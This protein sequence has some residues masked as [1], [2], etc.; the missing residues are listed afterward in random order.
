MQVLNVQQIAY[1]LPTSPSKKERKMKKRKSNKLK[2]KLLHEDECFR[3]GDGGDLVLC[4]RRNCPKCY[5]LKCLH[6]E[7]EP[8]GKWD[9]P[10]H[11]CDDCGKPSVKLCSECPNSFCQKHSTPDNIQPMIEDNS[12]SICNDH[13]EFIPILKSKNK[14]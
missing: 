14:S 6:L 5:H 7:Q 2:K 3:C 10:W 11:H 4:D 13:D 8:P 1:A 9:C 12:K